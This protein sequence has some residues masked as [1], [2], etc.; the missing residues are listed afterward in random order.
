[1]LIGLL[2]PTAP[3]SLIDRT[4]RDMPLLTAST[5][6][7]DDFPVIQRAR[8]AWSVRTLAE[9]ESD[10]FIADSHIRKVEFLIADHFWIV[11]SSASN[12]PASCPASHGVCTCAGPSILGSSNWLRVF[13]N[14]QNRL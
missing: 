1:M 13:C 8:T 14:R 12:C 4:L 6:W 5:S 11:F 9:Q 10:F 3:P 7:W 2:M